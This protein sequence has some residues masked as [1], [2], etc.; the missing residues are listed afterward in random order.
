MNLAQG[1]F[2]AAGAEDG[3]S[4]LPISGQ[5]APE[6]SDKLQNLALNEDTGPYSLCKVVDIACVY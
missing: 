2:D 5:P 3:T 4:S 1:H 6:V